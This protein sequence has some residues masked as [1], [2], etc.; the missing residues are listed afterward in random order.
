[1]RV[2]SLTIR[3]S[4]LMLMG[5]EYTWGSKGGHFPSELNRLFFLHSRGV[6]MDFCPKKDWMS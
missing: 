2:L 1:M 3:C 6:Y 5:P 4:F